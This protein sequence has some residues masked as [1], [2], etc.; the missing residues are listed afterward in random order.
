MSR[1]WVFDEHEGRRNHF[2]FCETISRKKPNQFCLVVGLLPSFDF[3]MSFPPSAIPP[4]TFF[5]GLDDFFQ[6]PFPLAVLR[7]FI[8]ALV[9]GFYF[10]LSQRIIAK[11]YRTPAEAPSCVAEDDKAIR[12]AVYEALADLEKRTAEGKPFDYATVIKLPHGHEVEI[13]VTAGCGKEGGK[14][15]KA[16]EAK[17]VPK[18]VASAG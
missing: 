10:Q 7:G 1:K 9:G 12:A 5:T 11:S 13:R 17:T 18:E 2:Q 4:T 15:T 16:T 3:T 6:Q 8:S 14:E